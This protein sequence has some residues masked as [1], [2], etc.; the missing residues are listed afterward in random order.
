M[1][2]SSYKTSDLMIDCNLIERAVYSTYTLYFYLFLGPLEI[3]T[4]LRGMLV[5]VLLSMA[6]Q[7]QGISVSIGYAGPAAAIGSTGVIY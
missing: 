7:I 2:K 1:Y 5:S 6:R 4:F 3:N